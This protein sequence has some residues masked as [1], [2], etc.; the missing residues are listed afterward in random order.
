MS[1]MLHATTRTYTYM[2]EISLYILTIFVLIN[3]FHYQFTVLMTD[4]YMD[5]REVT[6]QALEPLQ[7]GLEIAFEVFKMIKIS[8]KDID[9]RLDEYRVRLSMP[10][11]P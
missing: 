8:R 5:D 10:L 4:I 1:I 7:S 11:C 6:E 3:P 2:C 9:K